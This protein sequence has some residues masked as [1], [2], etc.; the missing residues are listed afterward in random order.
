MQSLLLSNVIRL[1]RREGYELLELVDTKPRCFDLIARKDKQIL[2][3]KVLYNVDSLKMETA[4]EMKKIARLL[5][6]TAIVIGERFKFD[7]LERR[8]VYT[9]YNLPVIN[10]ATFYDYLQ[11]ELPYIYSAPGGYYVKINAEKFRKARE[12]MGISIGDAAKRLGVSKRTVRNYEEGTDASVEVALKIEE[13]FGDVVKKINFS[14]FIHEK[15]ENIEPS[16]EEEDEIIGKLRE[17][18]M[19]VYTVKHTPFDAIS[20]FEE[21]EVIMGLKQ[22]REIEKRAR[23]IGKVSQIVKADAAYITERDL[24]KRVNSVVFVLK[25]ELES[26]DSPEDFISLINEKREK[27]A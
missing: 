18:G 2:L 17:I 22:V 1:L 4:E 10:L 15:E 8:V 20:K 5:N 11:G 13:V 6:A 16:D 25:E 12:A 14:E 27:Y 3:I 21:N 26:L 23:L 9:R 7:F 19:N 24:K